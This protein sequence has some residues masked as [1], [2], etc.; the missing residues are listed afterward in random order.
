[1]S[2]I[3]RLRRLEQGVEGLGR[4]PCDHCQAIHVQYEDDPEPEPCKVCGQ[5]PETTIRVVYVDAPPL[6]ER[7]K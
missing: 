1:M 2:L 6:L 4:I 5:L 7:G 3:G